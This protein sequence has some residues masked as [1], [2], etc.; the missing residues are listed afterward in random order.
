MIEKLC[1]LPYYLINIH[2]FNFNINYFQ[3]QTIMRKSLSKL[4]NIE[5][6]T[7]EES[8]SIKGGGVMGTNYNTFCEWYAGLTSIPM[9]EVRDHSQLGEWAYQ[10]DVALGLM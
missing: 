8:Q 6:L 7:K 3:N 9:S 10:L 4:Q 2:A 5:L 1:N